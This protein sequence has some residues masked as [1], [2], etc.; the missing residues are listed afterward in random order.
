MRRTEEPDSLDGR[1]DVDG[2]TGAQLNNKTLARS[3]LPSRSRRNS[4]NGRV[5]RR[6]L[7]R[8]NAH[9]EMREHATTGEAR[10]VHILM[11]RD[12]A[13]GV[14]LRT[15]WTAAGVHANEKPPNRESLNCKASRE[16]RVFKVL[17][18]WAPIL[19]H[20]GH[21]HAHTSKT[22]R[23]DGRCLAVRHRR[24]ASLLVPAHG[25]TCV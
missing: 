1:T 17:P 23:R 22:T 25:H 24:V 14:N 15:E 4:E 7:L 5:R 9:N 6:R 19:Y 11:E 16:R 13:A 8:P 10:G 21:A 20:E 18:E 2:L 12:G 3:Q